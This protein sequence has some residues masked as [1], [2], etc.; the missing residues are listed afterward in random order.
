M[1]FDDWIRVLMV[2]GAILIA[3]IA[4]YLKDRAKRKRVSV[5]SARQPAPTPFH[6]SYIQSYSETKGFIP[7]SGTPPTPPPA[8][9]TKRLIDSAPETE[10]ER[11]TIDETFAETIQVAPSPASDKLNL[12]DKDTLRRAIILSD[13][14]PPKF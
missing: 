4:T 2:F 14:L 7:T 10:G 6:S 12:H 1:D 11:V 3:S 8:P 5:Q 9:A 13:I